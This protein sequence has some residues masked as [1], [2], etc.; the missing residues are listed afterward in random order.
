MP[1]TTIYYFSATGNSL[2]AARRIA[3]TLGDAELV[4]IVRDE[5]MVS[6]DSKV[7]GLVFPVHMFGVPRI[8]V[9]FIRKLKAPAGAY[10]FA[11]ATSGGMPCSTLK[12]AARLFSQQGMTLSAGFSLPMVN[13]C[14]T[15]AAAPP[16]EKQ[17]SILKKAGQTIEKICAAVENRTRH[18]HR[19]LPII[20]WF[21]DRFVHQRALP[22]VPGMSKEYHTDDNC[23]GCGVCSR[24]CPVRNIV[25]DGQK[26]SWQRHCEACFACMQWCPKESIQL[27][28]KT[29]GRRRYH[30][31]DIL[32]TE[33][34][35]LGKKAA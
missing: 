17:R 3:S 12:E 28:N 6:C 16:L 21:F 24:V 25:M 4:S 9:R 20:N 7:I 15:V 13:N 18:I 29:A 19:G 34:A 31:P 35:S 32:L 33:I 5:P 11:V 30:H 1:N 23:D 27:G 14:T 26:P 22:K 8:V 10:I 2:V